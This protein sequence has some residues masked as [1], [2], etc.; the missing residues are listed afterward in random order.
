M[1][2]LLIIIYI[3][4]AC[5]RLF[6]QTGG[7]NTY[8]FLNLTHSAFAAATGG[9]TVSQ[10][11]SDLSLPYHNPALLNSSMRNDIALSYSRYLAGINYGYAAYGFGNDSVNNY[12]IGIGYVN[13][14][15]FTEA[16]EAGNIT[17]SFT[18]AEYVFNFIYSRPV[19]SLFTIGIDIKPV[20]SHL[21]KYFSAGICADIGITYINKE[22]LLSAGLVIKNAGF[23]IKTYTGNRSESLPFEIQAGV[24]KQLAHAPLRFT[25]TLRHLEKYDLTYDYN[26]SD[27]TVSNSIGE[28]ILRHVVLGVELLPGK[29][30]WAGAGLNYQR[31]A[32]LR[33]ATKAGSA[34]LS[35][36]FGF[37]ARA[38]SL[39]F[40]RDTY[41]LAGAANHFSLVLY[42]GM[43][44]KNRHI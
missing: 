37:N 23:Q 12:A 31:R 4:F 27:E 43:I 40:G 15:S 44:F 9:L 29:N 36:G 19:D 30:F 25:L 3:S 5:V 1:K 18:A 39:A 10:S 2:R 24:T 13:Y 26:T 6:S 21:E 11:R 8:E 34:G 22:S 41:H 14:G 28:N 16:D 20:L 33:T 38:F 42:P 7:D 17:G 32:E 35:W